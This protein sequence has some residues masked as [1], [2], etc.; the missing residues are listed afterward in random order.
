MAEQRPLEASQIPAT[1]LVTT[2]HGTKPLPTVYSIVCLYD[3]QEWVHWNGTFTCVGVKVTIPNSLENK[4]IL[5]NRD[6]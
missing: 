6:T 1:Y 5:N 4:L 2:G 3:Q